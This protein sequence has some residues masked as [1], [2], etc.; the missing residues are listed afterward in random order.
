M[1][2]LLNRSLRRCGSRQAQYFATLQ[3]RRQM[4][5]HFSALSLQECIF[6]ERG[7]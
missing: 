3:A 6:R 2:H 4:L 1:R 7:E 5:N